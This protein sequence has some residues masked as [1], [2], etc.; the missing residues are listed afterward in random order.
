MGVVGTCSVGGGENPYF[1]E[2]SDFDTLDMLGTGALLLARA[3]MGCRAWASRWF[4][5]A[6]KSG[7]L[8][9]RD[10]VAAPPPPRPLVPVGEGSDG[11]VPVVS[12]RCW[13]D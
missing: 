5:T 6:R 1:L 8:K 4:M 7:V 9:L 3:D 12:E 13:R 10:R 11:D 2:N